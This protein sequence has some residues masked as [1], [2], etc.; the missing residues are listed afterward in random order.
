[1]LVVMLSALDARLWQF[2]RRARG[3]WFATRAVLWHWVYY[4]YSTVTFA[5]GVLLYPLI[6]RRRVH[7]DGA[8]LLGG[9]TPPR[10]VESSR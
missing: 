5:A 7:P 10:H 9:R 8:R 4:G 1:M 6:G 2:F 3:P